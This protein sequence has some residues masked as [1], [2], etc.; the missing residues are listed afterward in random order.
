MSRRA[1]PGGN[2]KV[3]SL[4]RTVKVEEV[5]L[6]EYIDLHDARQHSGR[7]LEAVH[8]HKRLHSSLGYRPPDE[9]ETAYHSHQERAAPL[10]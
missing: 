10:A 8:N 2:A 4:F 5:Y 7:F 6:N 1:S 9:F 3:E